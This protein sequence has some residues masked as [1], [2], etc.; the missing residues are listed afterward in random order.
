MVIFLRT[1]RMVAGFLLVAVLLAACSS[2]AKIAEEKLVSLDGSS[3]TY[4]EELVP[5]SAWLMVS[6]GSV[7]G[8]QQDIPNYFLDALPLDDPLIQEAI[9]E[10]TMSGEA[11]PIMQL[12]YEAFESS[13]SMVFAAYEYEEDEEP[14]DEDDPF[15]DFYQND[16]LKGSHFLFAASHNS[17]AGIDEMLSGIGTLIREEDGDVVR[18]ENLE[19]GMPVYIFLSDRLFVVA[20]T[21]D[22]PMLKGEVV[23]DNIVGSKTYQKYLKHLEDD[24]LAYIF[25][26]TSNSEFYKKAFTISGFSRLGESIQMIGSVHLEEDGIRL[27]SNVERTRDTE[28]SLKP[29]MKGAEVRLDK[30]IPALDPIIYTES[31]GFG[32]LV[33]SQIKTMLTGAELGLMTKAEFQQNVEKAEMELGVKV[34]KELVPMLSNSFAMLVDDQ[35]TLLP[36]ISFWFD[37]AG[38]RETADVL[39]RKMDSMVSTA[40]T[41]IAIA[42]PSEK[43]I[44]ERSIYKEDGA[45]IV[46]YTLNIESIP[47]GEVGE[48]PQLFEFLKDD[49]FQFSYGLTADGLLFI[50]TG[51]LDKNAPR[52]AD[53]SLYGQFVERFPEHSMTDRSYIALAPLADYL[54]RFLELSKQD[55][56][57][58]PSEIDALTSVIKYMNVMDGMYT[59]SRRDGA[60]LEQQSIIVFDIDLLREGGEDFIKYLE[61]ELSKQELLN[62]EVEEGVENGELIL[63]DET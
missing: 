11:P 46:V 42:F 26:N 3:V 48:L 2:G 28:P 16:P 62:S 33:Y 25:M 41:S 38:H 10:Q 34:E 52:V 59:S 49:L 13:S 39:M 30:L 31:F 35:G 20:D 47:E 1:A 17:K 50:G 60:W 8:E 45:D 9:L 19:D 44:L 55:S 54:A 56:S 32:S 12:L 57:I 53:A 27:V 4:L 14:E 21:E 18:F 22:A 5:E 43:P 36:G 6:V 24:R 61:D 58:D 40:V 29:I 7:N 51:A 63:G 37:V 23:K 15:A